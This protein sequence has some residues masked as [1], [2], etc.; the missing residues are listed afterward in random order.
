MALLA[1]RALN[2]E[3]DWNFFHKRHSIT[4]TDLGLIRPLHEES[5]ASLWQELVS[6]NPEERH[7]MLLPQ[8]HWLGNLTSTGPD[9]HE[10]WSNPERPDA[11]TEFLRSQ[12]DW[13][14][15]AEV[16]FVW[17]REQAVRVP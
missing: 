15:T 10:F 14:E 5:A 3:T 4:P 9:W 11:V 8:G 17:M 12:I 7:P 16:F 13:P 6:A 1:T 2:S